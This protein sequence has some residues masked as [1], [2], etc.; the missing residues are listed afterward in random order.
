L[1]PDK[2]AYRIRDLWAKRGAGTTDSAFNADVPAHGV[3]MLR[4]SK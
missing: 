3:V 4:L 1:S 2:T